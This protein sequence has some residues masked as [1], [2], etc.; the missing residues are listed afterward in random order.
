MDTPSA[1]PGWYPDPSGRHEMRYFD[2]RAWTYD[3]SDRGKAGRE[4]PS[5]E[6]AAVVTT[7]WQAGT[8]PQWVNDPLPGSDELRFG[9]APLAGYGLRLWGAVLE[10]ILLV[11]TLVVGWLVW[12]L[13]KFPQ[14]QTPAKSLI[15]TRVVKA[16]TGEAADFGAMF[17]RNVVISVAL[18]VANLFTLGL[19]GLVAACLIFNGSLRQTGWDRI[20]GT[21]VVVDKEGRTVPPRR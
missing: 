3:V 7:G 4:E 14:G 1:P 2:G 16:A 21:V 8:T 10:L 11:C 20:V 6:Q 12:A 15:G 18:T 5:G 13:L 9:G 19:P 17:V